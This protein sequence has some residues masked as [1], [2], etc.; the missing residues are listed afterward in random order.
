M[1]WLECEASFLQEFFSRSNNN[2]DERLKCY[3]NTK[4]LKNNRT[5]NK[6]NWIEGGTTELVMLAERLEY[7]NKISSMHLLAPS[8]VMKENHLPV[9]WFTRNV[10]QITV[11]IIITYSRIMF[12]SLPRMMIFFSN[13]F[14]RNWPKRMIYMKSLPMVTFR[15]L[16]NH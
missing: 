3:L 16:W 15:I 7:N 1:L 4:R 6:L 2:T 10:N 11:I 5:L 12:S 14:K 13:F 8:I 9:Q